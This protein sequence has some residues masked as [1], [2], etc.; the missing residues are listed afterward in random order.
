MLPLLSVSV[1]V[2]IPPNSSLN[3]IAL[4]CAVYQ[5]GMSQRKACRKTESLRVVCLDEYSCAAG[6]GTSYD[7]MSP[8]LQLTVLTCALRLARDPTADAADRG[9]IGL[10][11]FAREASQWHSFRR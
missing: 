10:K 2:D 9:A 3:S 5:A 1:G 4:G 6:M 8:L 7:T 11:G